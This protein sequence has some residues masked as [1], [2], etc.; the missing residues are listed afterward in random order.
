MNPLLRM[1]LPLNNSNK[2]THK[3]MKLKYHAKVGQ[4]SSPMKISNHMIGFIDKQSDNLK[5]VTS[6]HNPNK[7]Y[8]VKSIILI[9]FTLI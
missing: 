9:F 1:A 7:I 8:L 6:K 4:R 3:G 5:G 2:N